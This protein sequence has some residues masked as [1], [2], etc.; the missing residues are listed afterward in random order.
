MEFNVPA[1]LISFGL[2]GG[3]VVITGFFAKKY[4]DRLET[5]GRLNAEGVEEAKNKA[6]EG[7]EKTRKEAAEEVESLRKETARDLAEITKQT[8]STLEKLNMRMTKELQ[9]AIHKN[10]LEY[11]ESSMEII[12]R[13][14]A[15]NTHMEIANGRTAKNELM[16][17]KLEGCLKTQKEICKQRNSGRR[18]SDHC[19]DPDK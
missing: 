19:D 3:L 2:N 5:R 18:S 12:K 13:L 7:I 6:A 10:R 11:K 15:V 4:F 8:A 17:V 14:D 9:D 1:I 16:I